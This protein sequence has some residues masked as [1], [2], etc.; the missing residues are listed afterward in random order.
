MPSTDSAIPNLP[1]SPD[2]CP[3]STLLSTPRVV[4]MSDEQLEAYVKNLRTCSESSQTLLKAVR[5]S[6]PD[7]ATKKE[8]KK[9]SRIDL[10]AL[11]L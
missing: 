11:G 8:K 9:A 4:D 10:G 1:Q 2:S 5:R 6:S 7:T 3:I